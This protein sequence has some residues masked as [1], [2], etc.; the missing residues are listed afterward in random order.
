MFVLQHHLK[1]FAGGPKYT[2]FPKKASVGAFSSMSLRLCREHTSW[3]CSTVSSNSSPVSTNRTGRLSPASTVRSREARES[4]PPENDTMA[5]LPV[6]SIVFRMKPTASSLRLTMTPSLALTT[7]S[8]VW[9]MSRSLNSSG[10]YHLV[11]TATPLSVATISGPVI[12]AIPVATT[13]LSGPTIMISSPGLM[14]G[15]ASTTP[16]AIR[17]LL[18]LTKGIAPG[19]HTTYPLVYAFPMR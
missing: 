7:S 17:F 11:L 9:G 5:V 14:S 3:T 2:R 4:F 10:L 15:S 12:F 6:L 19:S 1:S 18:S 13:S 16:G 8:Q